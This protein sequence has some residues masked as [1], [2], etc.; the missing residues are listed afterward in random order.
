MGDERNGCLG[1][2]ELLS[3]EFFKALAD[4]NRIAIL[5]RL[6][7]EG[8]EKTVSEVAKCCP[9]DVSVVSRHLKILRSAG[10]LEAEK[11]GKE[12]L[13]RIRIRHLVGLL[14]GLADALETCCP[15]GV[16]TIA[17]DASGQERGE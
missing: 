17:G 10:V 16:C 4:P 2:A 11:R 14:R 7:E 3:A 6:A 5:A 9:V 15:D 12:V 13:Y 1:L 8:R